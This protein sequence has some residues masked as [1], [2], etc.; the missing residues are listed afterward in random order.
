MRTGRPPKYPVELTAEEVSACWTAL[1]STPCFTVQRRCSLLL[2]LNN[3][4]ESNLSYKEVASAHA[5]NKD[6][7][8]SVAKRFCGGGVPALLSNKRNPNSDTAR[9]RLDKRAESYLV[10][11]ACTPPPEPYVRWTNALCAKKFNEWAVLNNYDEFSET[12]VWRGLQNNKIRPHLSEYWCIPEITPYFIMRMEKVLHIYASPFDTR[13]PVVCMDELAQQLL[14][15]KYTSLSPLP[16]KSGKVDFE[17]QR[18]GTKSIFA[19]LEPK[20]GQYYFKVRERHTAIEWAYEIRDMLD[21]KYPDAEKV[22][23]VTDNLNTHSIQSLYKAFPAEEARRLARRL[24]FCYTPRHGSWLDMAEIAINNV[25]RQCIGKRFRTPE[26]SEKLQDRL[27]LWQ[28]E[29]NAEGKPINWTFTVEKAR[30]KHPSLYKLSTVQQI[31][32]SE[33]YASLN[34]QTDDSANLPAVTN[35]STLQETQDDENVIELFQ[36]VDEQGNEYW[37]VSREGNR[38]TFTEPTGK[39]AVAKIVQ[40]RNSKVDGWIIPF[41]SNPKKPKEEGKKARDIQYAFP[42]MALGEDIVELYNEQ[43]NE[44]CPV[45]CV[46]KRA[47]DLEDPTK[48]AWV[49]NLKTEPKAKKKKNVNGNQESKTAEAPEE[50]EREEQTNF[51]TEESNSETQVDNASEETL[52]SSSNSSAEVQDARLGITLMYQPHTGRRGFM[53]SDYTDD[54]SW[55]EFYKDLVD[56]RYPEA[57]KIHV[58]VAEED[59]EKIASLFALY[60]PDEALRICLKVEIHSVPNQARWLNFAENEAITLFRKCVKDR[61]SSESELGDYLTSWRKQTAHVDLKINLDSFRE[62]FADVY[63]PFEKN[64]KVSSTIEVE[65]EG[66]NQSLEQ[67]NS[68]KNPVQPDG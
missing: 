33:K 32:S 25:K 18:L 9:L 26:E 44:N 17:Y 60:P 27:N 21:T 7:S 1:K 42:F 22:I 8:T 15:D 4:H 2:G 53:V 19:F 6:Y 23:L 63:K 29:K 16:G 31:P 20:R 49:S 67:V 45:V 56:N 14:A 41:P 24:Q 62:I 57:E 40:G 51:E 64:G 5:S 13:F 59:H 50:G 34:N 11:L 46:Q 38:V 47:Y 3:R 65:A 10:A 66:K 30:E 43:Y 28:T 58:V 68:E 48:N 52:P 36:S 12:T 61:V 55:G 35:F 37:S 39:L 54:L